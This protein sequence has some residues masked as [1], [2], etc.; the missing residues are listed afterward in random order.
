MLTTIE[1]NSPPEAIYA[2]FLCFSFR[3]SVGVS[4]P[5]GWRAFLVIVISFMSRPPM[6]A[7]SRPSPE[8]GPK[9]RHIFNFTPIRMLF[10][11]R[12]LP[13]FIKDS[14]YDFRD[15]VCADIDAPA[16]LA[17]G[18]VEDGFTKVTSGLDGLCTDQLIVTQIDPSV[19][20]YESCSITPTYSAKTAGSVPVFACF[21]SSHP[22]Y[23]P[24]QTPIGI[25]SAL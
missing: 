17:D 2:I 19:V 5:S 12:S 15:S 23:T 16:F 13:I 20:T 9:G 8:A 11:W 6:R 10:G 24:V 14:V 18:I 7:T 1:I 22:L 21:R 25:G 4:L 3:H